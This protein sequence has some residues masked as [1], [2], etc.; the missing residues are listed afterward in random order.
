MRGNNHIK[1]LAVAVILAMMVQVGFAAFSFVGSSDE[2]SK[3]D[4][5]TLKNIGKTSTGMYSLSHINAT[6]RFKTTRFGNFT[7]TSSNTVESNAMLQFKSGNTTYIY[8]YKVKVK[9]PKFK[10]PSPVNH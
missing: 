10:T 9:V 5:F 4:K 7:K 8:P 3:S 2:R 6:M 1:K